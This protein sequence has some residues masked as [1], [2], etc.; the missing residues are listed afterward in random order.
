MQQFTLK[1]DENFCIKCRTF[2]SELPRLI[3]EAKS[4][5]NAPSLK[6]HE[7]LF[8]LKLASDRCFLCLLFMCQRETL[9]ENRKYGPEALQSNEFAWQDADI[10]LGISQLNPESG[11]L[12]YLWPTLSPIFARRYFDEPLLA[13]ELHQSDS[14]AHPSTYSIPITKTS[15]SLHQ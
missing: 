5:F 1:M 7:F 2:V 10:S 15:G 3:Q 13:L 14:S 4:A 9:L 12:V 6:H 11:W 8:F